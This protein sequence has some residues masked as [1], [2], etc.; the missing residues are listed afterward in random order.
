MET[1]V[2]LAAVSELAKLGLMTYMSYM[3][4]AGLNEQQIDVVYQAAKS[5]MLSRDP[6][7]I[8]DKK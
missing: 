2:A 6:S 1:E 3:Q 4:T 7:N 8:P 5:A